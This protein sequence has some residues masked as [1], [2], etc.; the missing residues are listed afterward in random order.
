MNS[1]CAGEKILRER[2]G[3][4]CHDK[5]ASDGDGRVMTE[6][7]RRRQIKMKERRGVIDESAA[8]SFTVILRRRACSYRDRRKHTYM[9]DVVLFLHTLAC[10]TQHQGA[11]SASLHPIRNENNTTAQFGAQSRCVF[12]ISAVLRGLNALVPQCLYK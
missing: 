6:G 1:P 2:R 11:E 7:M 12:I 4:C 5:G 10:T 8:S 9:L 3:Y